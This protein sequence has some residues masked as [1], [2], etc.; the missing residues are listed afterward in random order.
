MQANG[1]VYFVVDNELKKNKTWICN[2]DGELLDEE[3]GE[4]VPENFICTVSHS[5]TSTRTVYLFLDEGGPRYNGTRMFRCNVFSTFFC[6]RAC[7]P[8]LS[9]RPHGPWGPKDRLS[10]YG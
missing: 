9:L 1:I 8:V 3:G 7:L 4:L 5:N 2:D 6:N 10:T